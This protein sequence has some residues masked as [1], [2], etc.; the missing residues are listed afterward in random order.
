ML[1]MFGTGSSWREYQM[2]SM[3]TTDLLPETSEVTNAMAVHN[4]RILLGLQIISISS[5]KILLLFYYYYAGS[6]IVKTSVFWI[7]KQ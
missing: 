7:E 6:K 1:G 5:F 2:G 4:N 3:Q